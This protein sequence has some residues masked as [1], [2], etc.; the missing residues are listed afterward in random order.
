MAFKL[1]IDSCCELPDALRSDPRIE[2]IPF[3]ME[4]G[5]HQLVDDETFDQQQF[6]RWIAESPTHP[7]SAC[8]SPEQF[9]QAYHCD[10]DVD[11][12]YVVTVSSKL[13]GSHNSAMLGRRLFLEKEQKNIH[14]CDS[15]SAVSGEGQI[16]MKLL[17][18]VG[19]GLPFTEVVKRITAYRDE[20]RTY[21]VLDN[22]ET[23][24]K[25]G[26]LVGIKAIV[27]GALNIKPV[28]SAV[29]GSIVQ[30]SQAIGIKK[31]LTRMVETVIKERPDTVASRLSIAHCNCLQRALEVKGMFENRANYKEIVVV[32]T[33]GVSSM[34]ANDGGV[35][36]GV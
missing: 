36:I 31:A 8:P 16:A 9:M 4:V 29:K 2:T 21:F 27:A 28:M 34:Y 15:H 25:N 11:D 13:S 5:D 19:L 7:K 17:D 14:V 33:K 3:T 22:L 26:R 35:V 18:L 23:L 1:V 20:L 32:G 6:L 30:K 12:V 24:R 10:S